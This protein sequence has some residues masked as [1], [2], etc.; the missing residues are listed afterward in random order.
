MPTKRTRY[1]LNIIETD[2]PPKVVVRRKTGIFITCGERSR[3][4][5]GPLY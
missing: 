5:K 1:L 2:T 4:I 3:T